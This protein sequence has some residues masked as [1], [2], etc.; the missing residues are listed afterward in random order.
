MPGI[1]EEEVYI[2]Q[3]TQ[4]AL[5]LSWPCQDQLEGAQTISFFHTLSKTGGNQGK[6]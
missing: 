3:E 4:S 2:Q 1:S 5:C 6:L